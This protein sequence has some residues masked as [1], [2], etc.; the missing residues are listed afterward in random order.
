MECLFFE[1]AGLSR[2][3][4]KYIRQIRICDGYRLRCFNAC[5]FALVE[6]EG[7]IRL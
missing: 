2:R 4:E 6:R 3:L 1:M 5:L 7:G